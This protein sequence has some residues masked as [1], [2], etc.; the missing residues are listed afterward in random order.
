MTELNSDFPSEEDIIRHSNTDFQGLML[1][2]QVRGGNHLIIGLGGGPDIMRSLL[3]GAHS[4]TAVDINESL[5]KQMATRFASYS[6][7]IF[8]RP[9]VHL[10]HSE[11]RS[12]LHRHKDAGQKFDLIQMTGVDTFTALNTGA[13]TLAE[14]HLYTVEA[15]KDYYASLSD[16][17][18]LSIHR[19]FNDG[20]PRETFRLFATIFQ[21][22]RELRVEHPEQHVAV[23]YGRSGIT[24]LKKQSI[25]RDEAENLFLQSKIRPMF[26]TQENVDGLMPLQAVYLPHLQ[27]SGNHQ[28]THYFQAFADAFS[29][30]NEQAFYESYIYDIRPSYD[31]KPFFFNYYKIH[32][33][34]VGSLGS[35]F[36]TG[37]IQ[38]Y[39]P[40]LVLALIFI[41]ASAAVAFF[42]IFPL[43]LLAKEGIQEKGTRLATV[44]FSSIGLGFIMIEIAMMQ[45]LALLLGHPSYSIATVLGGLLAFSGMGSLSTGYFSVFDKKNIQLLMVLALV[46]YFGVFLSFGDD[47]ISHCLGLDLSG[48]ILVAL[49][50]IAPIGFAL[51]IF[52]PM[53]LRFISIWSPQFIPW[54]WGVNSGF[55]VI[56]SV[57][58]IALAMW[59]GFSAVLLL[60]CLFYITAALSLRRLISCPH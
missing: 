52:F 2:E 54:A 26:E 36:S 14:N 11:G 53:G 38:G 42:I 29:S 56:G 51:G 15:I 47:L 1:G 58:A 37:P 18:V 46:A 7:D 44:Y 24:Y 9:N 25:S 55:T 30:N 35:I 43:Y 20:K 57:A 3:N 5:L 17:G 41:S 49:A 31:D 12:Y 45:K 22:L 19:W 10:V 48:R 33:I 13:Y 6:G 32:D 23:I 16:N 8:N 39:W 34:F 4:I 60:S 59:V 28:S 50:I 21:A 40:Y 27:P